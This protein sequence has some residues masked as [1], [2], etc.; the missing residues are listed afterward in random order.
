MSRGRRWTITLNNPVIAIEELWQPDLFS[1]L[2]AALEEGEQC[3]TPHYQIYLETV[4]KESIGP[5]AI[6]LGKRWKSHPKL[7]QSGGTADQN[8]IYCL[9]EQSP[10][11]TEMGTAMKPGARSDIKGAIEDINSGSSMHDLWTNHT[12]VMIKFGRGF[13]E[14]YS[15]L[16]P[17]V[18]QT[19][20]KTYT[21]EEFQGWEDKE[22]LI[23]SA[24]TTHSVIL[25]GEPG[26]GKT[27]FA[28]ALLPKALFV[29][30]MDDLTKYDTGTMDGIIFDDMSL[31]HLPREAQIQVLD[32]EQ[33][34][35]IHC[36]YTTAFIPSGTKKIFTT[37][38]Y[39]GE[40]YMKGEGAL[41]RRVQKFEL[42]KRLSE[43][44]KFD[45]AMGFTDAE[46]NVLFS[47]EK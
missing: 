30:H 32:T 19:A 16:S 44:D 17:N 2:V 11:W 5:L 3:H 9:K 41:D 6:N 20:M 47:W 28:R 27:C 4:K 15:V 35:S 39:N 7:F 31:A 33:P 38:I 29:T 21:V 42:R 43:R 34:R 36:R 12:E 40:I 46:G 22:F 18:K 45:Q 24:M 14:A 8:R 26:C 13:K 37:N 25:W 23:T 10:I 1:Y